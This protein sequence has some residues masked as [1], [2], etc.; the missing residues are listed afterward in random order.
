MFIIPLQPAVVYF[1][2]ANAKVWPILGMGKGNQFLETMSGCAFQDRHLAHRV[3][4]HVG[5][6]HQH[7]EP[8]H[9]QDNLQICYRAYFPC[10]S[11]PSPRTRWAHR[12]WGGSRQ[13]Q[14]A[15]RP[16]MVCCTRG[17]ESCS[18]HPSCTRCAPAAGC[19]RWRGQT[20]H[21]S[22]KGQGLEIIANMETNQAGNFPFSPRRLDVRHAG[23]P[24][25]VFRIS[26]HKL[27]D[28]IDLWRKHKKCK[29]FPRIIKYTHMIY[30]NMK[31]TCSRKSCTASWNWA[32]HPM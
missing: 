11:S 30:I 16:P 29:Y 10:V 14:P 22:G 18:A 7:A 27:V 26:C 5:E 23:R 25:Q 9:L 20:Q 12:P 13:P 17:S 21:Q 24:V 19:F 4:R 3:A 6:I 8:V 2:K 31:R 15:R 32:L 28:Y 1:F